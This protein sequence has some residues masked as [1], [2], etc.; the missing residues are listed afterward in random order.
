MN[1]KLKRSIAVTL[2]ATSICNPIS[3]INIFSVINNNPVIASA[4]S[5]EQPYSSGLWSKYAEVYYDSYE[6]VAL[7]YETNN[8]GVVITGCRTTKP[9]TTVRIPKQLSGKDVVAIGDYAFEGQTNISYVQFYGI[10]QPLYTTNYYP[11]GGSSYGPRIIKG[12]SSISKIGKNAFKNCTNLIYVMVGEKELKIDDYA[13]SGCTKLSHIKFYNASNNSAT[14]VFGNIGKGAFYKCGITSFG[15]LNETFKCKS[16]GEMAFEQ[17]SKLEIVNFIADSV[18]RYSFYSCKKLKNAEIE[19]SSIDS[20]AF[21]NCS[22]LETVTLSK[23]KSIGQYAFS[24]CSSL[25]TAAIPNAIESIGDFAFFNA[26]KLSTPALFVN[27]IYRKV[28]IGRY[29]FY[30]TAI[31]YAVF[32][33][34]INV[35][36]YAFKN[37]KLKAAVVEGNV[38]INN[39]ALGYYNSSLVP[40][41]TMYVDELYNGYAST[42]RILY[43]TIDKNKTYNKIM[44]EIKPYFV[45]PNATKFGN[46]NGCC[47]G[48]ALTQVLTYTNKLSFSEL[49]PSEYN[50]RKI[51]RFLDVPDNAYSD[52]I[53][54]FSKFISTVYNY[55]KNQNYYLFYNKGSG[56]GYE[57]TLTPETIE[58]YS[59]LTEYGIVLPAVLH[60]KDHNHAVSLFGVE[61]LDTPEKITDDI[62]H[63]EKTYNYRLIISENGYGFKEKNG[64][65]VAKG[66]DHFTWWPGCTSEEGWIPVEDTYIYIS[67]NKDTE[68]HCYQ[69]RWDKGKNVKLGATISTLEDYDMTLASDI[70]KL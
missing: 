13:F 39:Y 23:T 53:P 30:N 48:V 34:N 28:N 65:L 31:E 40:G 61:K 11:G 12:G 50:G 15:D 57:I 52:N 41:F 27:D 20:Y 70:G 36:E 58:G 22:S 2:A 6:D 33:G 37:C 14:P 42:N 32:S 1:N 46:D 49:F 55:W 38:R 17:C 4:E 62:S 67:T 68:G 29:A 59:K 63:T 9:N 66:C 64:K 44:D 69:Q 54:E 7:C 18:G 51:T 5:T 43:K 60:V 19:S 8:D 24:G 35:G 45:R 47:A 25:K 16:I 56:S 21:Y 10:N 3:Q 26:S